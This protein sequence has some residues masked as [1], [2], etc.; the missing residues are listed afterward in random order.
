MIHTIPKS[1]NSHPIIS[2]IYNLRKE[3]VLKGKSI[4]W[5]TAEA[6]A[7]AT[8]LYEGYGIRLSGEDVQRGTFS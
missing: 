8:L 2:K 5:A 7:F 3:S 1:F 4:E 6:L